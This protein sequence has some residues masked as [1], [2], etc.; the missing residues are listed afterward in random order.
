M[1]KT[2]GFD[3]NGKNRQRRRGKD[4]RDRRREEIDKYES[5]TRRKNKLERHMIEDGKRRS[6]HYDYRNYDESED[7]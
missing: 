2:V 7:F 3:D 6:K 1:V 5:V 4:I